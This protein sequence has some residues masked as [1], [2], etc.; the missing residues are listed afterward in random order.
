ME[1][2]KTAV[3]GCGAFAKHQ[4]FP[5]IMRSEKLE[6]VAG[7]SRSDANRSWVEETC[8]PA[9][10]TP[11]AA[12]VFSD[13]D[14]DLIDICLHNNWHAPV[15][16]AAMEAG[17]DVYCEKPMA[18][19][20]ADAKAMYDCSVRTGRK[21]H[22]QLS[23]IYSNEA[24]AAKRFI[25][26]DMLGEIYHMR[27]YGFRRR[28]R[29][30]VDGYARKEFVNTKTAGGGALFDMGVYHISKLL[31]L[32]GIPKLERVCGSVYAKLPMDEKRRE[33]SGYNVEE[34]G[35]GYATY[36]GGLTMDILESWA[37]YARPFPSSIICGSKGGLSMSPL[38]FH[39]AMEDIQSDT[40]F[41]LSQ[42]DYLNHT[43]YPEMAMYDNSQIHLIAALQGKCE[44]L[45]TRE[46]ALQ[47]QLVQEGIYIS[48]RL[49][50]EVTAEE[51]AQHSVSTALE[52]PNLIA[53][54][55]E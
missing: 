41:D 36:E 13:P 52:V 30:Y 10:T 38:T 35:T 25:E 46:I 49:G 45:P 48:N 19:S 16:I 55:K 20:Y 14:I 44:L 39:S 27:S 11:E 18:G 23:M 9:Y 40:T 6:L 3:V 43:V 31:W 54:G 4:H 12:D 50:R 5:N 51:I 24:K 42:F 32:T 17:K 34:L 21:L 26:A 29:P 33:I 22:I 1:S 47:T 28:G 8:C 37:I 15:A 53:D 7:C 2:I